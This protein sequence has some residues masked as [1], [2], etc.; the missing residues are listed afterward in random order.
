MADLQV[1]RLLARAPVEEE[2]LFLVDFNHHR[3]H[4]NS[5][6]WPD[7]SLFKCLGRSTLRQQTDR[8]TNCE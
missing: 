8:Q 6:R 3:F 2:K 4:Q 1:T 5:S 7:E